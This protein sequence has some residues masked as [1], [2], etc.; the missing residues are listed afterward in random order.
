MDRGDSL[1]EEQA[2]QRVQSQMPATERL[3][4]SQVIINSDQ[5][6][7]ETAAN[8]AVL[9]AGMCTAAAAAAEC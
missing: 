3:R 1:T 5:T 6:K 2:R 9:Y 7:P 4:R 8:V